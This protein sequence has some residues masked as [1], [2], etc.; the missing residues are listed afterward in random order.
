MC[1]CVCRRLG[2]TEDQW[3]KIQC[4][5]SK[6]TV[7]RYLSS[8]VFSSRD[9]SWS[10]KHA[11]IHQQGSF[12]T[13]QIHCINFLAR[14]NL[15]SDVA[16]IV[17]AQCVICSWNILPQ[18]CT[19]RWTANRYEFTAPI[20]KFAEF[21]PISGVKI[22][23]PTVA[24]GHERTSRSVERYSSPFTY[25]CRTPLLCNCA[26]LSGNGNMSNTRWRI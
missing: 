24:N 16:L 9:L 12:W 25:C 2:C 7:S 18:L 4:R 22:V 17:L 3:Y 5:M 8:L 23:A 10:Q 14:R 6:G 21:F 13:L 20:R 1:V 26:V 15:F 19:Q 11:C